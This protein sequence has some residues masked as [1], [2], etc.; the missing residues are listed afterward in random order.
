MTS[1]I[2]AEFGAIKVRRARTAYLRIKVDPSGQISAT[3]PYYATLI[4]LR[5]L[6]E[7]NRASL[8]KTIKKL[9]PR[10]H[11]SET[12]V[13]E[14]RAK[15]RKYLPKRLEYLADKYGFK[16]GKV[17]L[18]NQK[19]RW[20]S[21]SRESNISLNIA[22][23]TLPVDL[24]DYVLLHELTHTEF[25]N[26]SPEFWAKLEEICPDTKKHR[27]ELKKYNSYLV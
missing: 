10:R 27:R 21:C 6:I 17:S 1:I 4:T 20:G 11:Y 22:L 14:I 3:I 7:K 5:L 19:T 15:A 25:M 2:D 13:K 24:I 23:V 18:R 26:H 12:A 9:P 16:Y 8:R